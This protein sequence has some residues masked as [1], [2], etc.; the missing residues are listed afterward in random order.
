MAKHW[1]PLAGTRA[2]LCGSTGFGEEWCVRPLFKSS[3]VVQE[4]PGSDRPWNMSK[5]IQGII[6]YDVVKKQPVKT[7]LSVPFPSL[8]RYITK[9]QK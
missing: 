6:F 4:H 1:T 2:N 9:C 3:L 8:A 5:S 7:P